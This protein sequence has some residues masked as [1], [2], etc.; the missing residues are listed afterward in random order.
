KDVN[1][2]MLIKFALPT[3]LS[4][5]F[6]NAFGI[7]D[8][9]FVMRMLDP[10][11]MAAVGIVW[12]FVMFAL[13]IGFMLGVGGNVLAAKRIGQGEIKEARSNFNLIVVTSF[14]V[15]A[16]MALGGIL[17]T[18][19]LLNILG[20][21]EE[22]FNQSLQYMQ[23]MLYFLPFILLGV[24]FQQFLMTE[25]K[26]N[27]SMIAFIIGG[28]LSVGLNFLLI[29]YLGWGLRGAALATSIGYTVPSIVGII[30]FT[31]IRSG[32][33]YFSK[34]K[35]SFKVL[36]RSAINGASEMVTMLSV[37][38]VS[39]F[40]NNIV[41][42]LPSGGPLGVAS[43]GIGFS[44]TGILSS[45]FIGFASGI[46]P[47]ISYNFGKEHTENLK[48]L[49]S[50]SLRI[51][52]VIAAISISFGWIFTS[53]FLRIYGNPSDPMFAPVYELAFRGIRIM[54]FGFIFM[55]FNTFASM[56]FTGFNDGKISSLLSFFR[57][58][59][60]VMISL[61]ILPQIFEMDG[62]WAA[63]PFA[64]VPALLMTI[65]LLRTYKNKYR[66]A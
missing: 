30:Y 4:M 10:S 51:I 63:M 39:T 62:V 36:G 44:I 32:N 1:A 26:A 17:F 25:G 52:A 48:K 15:S 8:G 2:K 12:P 60:F 43:V 65:Y 3:L 9:I 20:A 29:G 56:F 35:F 24:V 6:M 18:E 27:I 61:W 41:M 16:V 21:N 5:V 54:S 38:I 55:G 49:Y 58:L 57:T 33:L 53:Q 19:Q 31:F 11:A 23:P 22:I 37:S 40:M 7:V 42:N 64:E 45:V 13:S 28:L 34:P 66:Y 50:N 46:V 47:I 14:I 59:V